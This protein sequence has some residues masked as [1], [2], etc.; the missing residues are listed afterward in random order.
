MHYGD[1]LF[2][3]GI[4]IFDIC[5]LICPYTY[6]LCSPSTSQSHVPN[7]RALPLNGTNCFRTGTLCRPYYTADSGSVSTIAT[8]MAS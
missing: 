8:I 2:E 7:G 5:I 1:A 6:L 3:K 4:C